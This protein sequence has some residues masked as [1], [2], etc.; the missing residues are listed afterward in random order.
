VG[1]TTKKKKI[2]PKNKGDRAQ[3][4]QRLPQQSWYKEEIINGPRLTTRKE[5]SSV[6]KRE[7][8]NDDFYKTGKIFDR[9]GKNLNHLMGK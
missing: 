4:H 9:T 8:K 7:M 3:N 1:K 6:R 5:W 2:I